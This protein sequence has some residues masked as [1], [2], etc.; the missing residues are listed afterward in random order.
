MAW[1]NEFGANFWMF[2][3]VPVIAL[4]G[5]FFQQRCEC[6][7]ERGWLILEPAEGRIHH[8]TPPVQ[9]SAPM[10]PPA[11][12]VRESSRISGG[13]ND[14]DVDLELGNSRTA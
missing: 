4:L 13:R 8:R 9:E 3:A 12:P 6:M 2:I 10:L 5:K 11:T 14:S 7:T 1:Y